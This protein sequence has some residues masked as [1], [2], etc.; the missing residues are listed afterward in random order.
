MVLLIE[1]NTINILMVT[2]LDV[3]LHVYWLEAKVRAEY[4]ARGGKS[5]HLLNFIFIKN[6]SEII[7]ANNFIMNLK[8]GLEK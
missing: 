5:R 1:I 2:V 4:H 6:F 8:D 7:N 3:L